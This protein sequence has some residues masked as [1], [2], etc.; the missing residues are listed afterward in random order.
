MHIWTQRLYKVLMKRRTDRR[1]PGFTGALIQGLCSAEKF[2]D[3]L[4]MFQ[5]FNSIAIHFLQVE[6]SAKT[7]AMCDVMIK[8]RAVL[9]Q[10]MKPIVKKIYTL[11][12]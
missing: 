1:E 5:R 9:S 3:H 8:N 10:I 2:N 4:D 11:G 7:V 6:I 12:N